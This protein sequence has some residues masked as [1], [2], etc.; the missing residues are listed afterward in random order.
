MPLVAVFQTVEHVLCIVRH[1]LGVI[2]ARGLEHLHAHHGAGAVHVLRKMQPLPH[3]RSEAGIEGIEYRAGLRVEIL[4]CVKGSLV[5]PCKVHAGLEGIV[6]V[7]GEVFVDVVVRIQMDDHVIRVVLNVH[8]IVYSELQGIQGHMMLRVRIVVDEHNRSCCLCKLRRPVRAV[9]RYYVYIK[10]FSRIVL[11]LDDG[12]HRIVN[13]ILLIVSGDDV[14]YPS[15]LLTPRILL[16]RKPEEQN[17][18]DLPHQ[19]YCNYY[20]H[21]IVDYAQYPVQDFIPHILSVPQLRIL[22][23]AHMFNYIIRYVNC[24]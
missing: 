22:F 17:Y 19:R 6:H 21:H 16:L 23:Q 15:L 2:S 10:Q 1:G 13:D 3:S 20:E 24:Q 7:Q 9:V 12:L 8:D 4:C 11:L 14:S 5:R 18:N